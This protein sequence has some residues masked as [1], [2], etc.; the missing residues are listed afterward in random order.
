MNGLFCGG[1]PSKCSKLYESLHGP[2][3][4]QFDARFA[5]ARE[6]CED[7]WSEFC[8]LSDPNFKREFTLRT[9]E[10]WF[11]MYLTVSLARAGYDVTCSN[12]GPDILLRLG[13]QRIWIEA[14]CASSGERGRPDS[15]PVRVPG[16]VRPEPTEQYVLRVRN[17][18][19]EKQKKYRKYLENGTVSPDDVTVVAVNVNQIDGLGFHIDAHLRRSL[20]GIGHPIVQLDQRRRPIGVEHARVE[21]VSKSSG[22]AVGL[23]PFINHSTTHVSALLASDA[24]MINRPAKLGDDFVLY[25]NVSGR[26]QWPQ[27]VLKLGRE[28]RFGPRIDG[29]RGTLVRNDDS[30]CA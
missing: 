13:E 15:I 8:E 4:D 6:H 2:K 5:G 23:L 18:L 20:Y 12:P 25:P 26:T 19:E 27:G 11:E 29:W 14:V 7:M 28:W 22:A 1:L 21:S 24:N 17:S 3:G 10:R 16:R 30:Q 9:H